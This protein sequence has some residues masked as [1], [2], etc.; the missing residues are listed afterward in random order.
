MAELNLISAYQDYCAK[1]KSADEFKSILDRIITLTDKYVASTALAKRELTTVDELLSI[2]QE[3]I[4]NTK[5]NLGYVTRFNKTLTQL[6]SNFQ[7][8]YKAIKC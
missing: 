8:I 7:Q 2:Y 6:T 5:F 4:A 3:M 1:E